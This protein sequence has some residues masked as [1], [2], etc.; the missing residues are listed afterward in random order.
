MAIASIVT[1]ISSTPSGV[2]DIDA[3]SNIVKGDAVPAT[4]VFGRLPTYNYI[5]TAS[6]STLAEFEAT[7]G[8]NTGTWMYVKNII[9]GTILANMELSIVDPEISTAT[10]SN[11]IIRQ[12]DGILG[13]TGTYELRYDT[14][15]KTNLNKG[16]SQLFTSTAILHTGTEVV[17]VVSPFGD[18]EDGL[19]STLISTLPKSI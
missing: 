6:T 15:F 18:L 9:T 17:T 11:S 14:G 7:V 10:R 5:S 12:I 13:N 19:F 16:N 2:I 4:Q 8:G 3:E 1:A